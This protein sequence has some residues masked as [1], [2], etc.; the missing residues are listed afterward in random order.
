MERL[1]LLE[2]EFKV[3]VVGI[4]FKIVILAEQTV[5]P[6]S[7]PSLGVIQADQLSFMES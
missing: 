2:G 7:I 3:G 4:R 5:V 1:V 6:S